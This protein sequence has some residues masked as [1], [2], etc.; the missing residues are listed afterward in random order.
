MS[1]EE[2]MFIPVASIDAD[3]ARKFMASHP[4]GSY[5]ILDVR[6]PGEYQEAHL[7]GGKLIP[8]PELLAAHKKLDPEKPII[9]H[10]A[11]GRRSLVAAQMLIGLGYREVYNLE[12]GIQAYKGEKASGAREFNLDLIRGD[13]TPS[14]IIRLAFGME[15]CLELFY[16]TMLKKSQ[17]QELLELFQSLARVEEHHQQTLQEEYA[18]V[19]P[20]GQN[21]AELE[22]PA[23]QE[24]M[25]GGFR[26]KEFMEANAPHLKKVSEVLELAMTLETQSL[27]LYLRFAD[28]CSVKRTKVILFQ[29]AKA[30]NAHL[31]RLGSLLEEKLAAGDGD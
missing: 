28:R 27:D 17:D 3:E 31:A 14:E 25:E 11:S 22:S 2:N 16:L 10:C 7:P 5:T 19:A 23:V 18:K 1:P 9:V 20:E 29:L 6:Q 15:K 12:G 24:I 13:E 4:A 21:L 26:M 8:L 30:E